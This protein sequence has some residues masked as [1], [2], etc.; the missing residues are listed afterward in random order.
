MDAKPTNFERIGIH[1]F[2]DPEHYH[3]SDL[4]RWLPRLQ[5]LGV[6]WIVLQAPGDRA[7]PEE[8]IT[9]LIHAGIQPILHFMLPLE[10]PE[11]EL[12]LT[13]LLSAYAN[14]GVRHVAFFDRPN[15]R[16]M[17][18]GTGWTQRGLVE[19][20]LDLF[21]PLANSARKVGLTPVFPPLEPGGD[22]WDT[23]FLRA[24]LETLD[25]RGEGA[26]IE[27]MALGAYA[28][29]EDKSLNWGV[30]GPERWPA[31]LPYH[32]PENSEDQRGFRIFDWYNAVTKA[33]IGKELPIL[34]IAAGVH[35]ENKP[36]RDARPDVRAV[37]IAE[38]MQK[39]ISEDFDNDVPANVL[40]CNLW[41][42]AAETAPEAVKNKLTWFEITGK[43]TK[44]AEKWFEWR[45]M[46]TP[47]RNDKSV[48]SSG[49]PIEAEAETLFVP[50]GSHSIRH[51]LL[52]PSAAE[53]FNDNI[54]LFVVEHQPTIGYS[55]EE[56]I[57]AARVTL[58]GGLQSFSDELIRN[59]ISAGC[60]VDSLPNY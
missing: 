32:T 45:G 30:G 11:T 35:R 43:P 15:L 1:Y 54:K 19:R 53:L 39:K 8:F 9:A 59:L 23:A 18:P 2:A 22:Y 37:K 44:I 21:E 5:K 38:A 13:P 42:L 12:D 51:Y 10:K 34:I 20:F 36:L 14:W 24:S 4:E 47:N 28:W 27:S 17:W 33:A 16:S 26:L 40:A 52:V 48:E 60:Q 58:A 55:V 25:E 29:T 49:A 7:I 56:A 41:L 31:T 3:R 6:Q 57:H 46:G 50:S